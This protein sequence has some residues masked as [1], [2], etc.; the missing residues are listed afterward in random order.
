MS[1]SATDLSAD[2]TSKGI[3]YDSFLKLLRAKP[4]ELDAYF[5]EIGTSAS[6]DSTQATVHC[7]YLKLDG[8]GLPR[9]K[10]LADRLAR[11]LVNYAIPRSEIEKAQK[12]AEGTLDSKELVALYR[13]ANRLF[14]DVA[15]TGEG[16]EL[17]LYLMMETYLKIPQLFCK[18]P[19]K[20]NP[21][22][23]YHGADGIHGSYDPGTEELALYWGESK[24]HKNTSDAISECF[25]S[26]APFVLPQ[27]GSQSPQARDLQ[28]LRD[29]L[30]LSDPQ[31][32][33][34]LLR[35]LDPDDPHFNKLKF[36][37]AALVGFDSD[38]YQP[39]SQPLDDTTL[40][41]ALEKTLNSWHKSA[42][43]HIGKHKLES[44][45]VELFCVPFPSVD[46]FRKAFLAE[47]GIQ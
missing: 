20:T 45:N 15:N 40:K 32:E 28:L 19:L 21:N 3:S 27:G 10:D 6:L 37:G 26:L 33:K 24:L 18:M 2:S 47:L 11:E 22:V 34:A 35:Y 9:I 46:A 30:D 4:Q 25:E 17:L 5:G 23:H 8:N 29:G 41:T 14:V 43:F 16:G 12:S 7:R 1:S 13:K 42:S 39:G 44:I 36:C 38:T 31:L